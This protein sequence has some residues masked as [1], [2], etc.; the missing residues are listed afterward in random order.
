MIFFANPAGLWALLA[1]PVIVAIHCLQERARH[2]RVST[3]FL[4]ERVAPESVSG[5]TFERLRNSLV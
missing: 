2:R 3:L 1:L 5:A 4:L